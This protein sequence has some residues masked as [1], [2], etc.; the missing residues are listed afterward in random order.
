MAYRCALLFCEGSNCI[1]G[2]QGGINTVQLGQ[3]WQITS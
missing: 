1:Q 3:C 2:D